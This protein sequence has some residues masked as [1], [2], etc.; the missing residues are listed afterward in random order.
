[1]KHVEDLIRLCEAPG[2]TGF[3][4][5]AAET[6]ASLLRPWCD[7][8]E[9]DPLGS[10]RGIRRCGRPD[11]KTLLLDA[12]IDQ[13]GFLVTEVLDGGFLRFTPV[14]GVDPR[15][16]LGCEVE[17][18]TPEPVFGVIACTPPHLLKAGEERKSIPIHKMLIDT[19][20]TDARSSIPIGTPVVFAQKP[21]QL[22]PDSITGKCLDDRAGVF[23]I[24]QALE[25]LHNLPLSVDLAVQFSVQEEVT[26]LGAMTG[27]FRIKPDFAIAVD[28]SHAK[29]PDAPAEDTFLYGGGVMIGMGP[30]FNAPLT[31][32]LIKTAKAED[33][34]YQ[35]EVMEGNTGTNAWEMQIAAAGTAMALLS[36]PLRYMHTPIESILLSDLESVSSLLYHFVRRFDGEVCL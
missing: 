4:Q 14:G 12:H 5:A 24:I 1:M 13:I 33:L 36:I 15:M 11:A 8:V 9:I 25:Q 21:V 19:G 32:A 30:N 10:V 17:I 35:L 23:A 20:L 29:T 6:A 27:A 2:I 28:V 18:L 34:D 26:A 31:C 16:L 3:E 7:S 22:T